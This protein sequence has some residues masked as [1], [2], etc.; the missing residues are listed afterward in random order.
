MLLIH[1]LYYLENIITKDLSTTLHGGT[2]FFPGHGFLNFPFL[3]LLEC[4]M[5]YGGS[6]ASHNAA[7]LGC[8][9]LGSALS[10]T[11]RYPRIPLLGKSCMWNVSEIGQPPPPPPLSSGAAFTFRCCANLFRI[12]VLDRFILDTSRT[13]E[14]V[15][16][17]HH[18]YLW[19]LKLS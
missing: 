3:W 10:G 4:W 18:L 6:A 8:Q 14:H 2:I 17:L 16:F 1:L 19:Y 9:C 15:R 5:K 13:T 7:G 12:N 11:A